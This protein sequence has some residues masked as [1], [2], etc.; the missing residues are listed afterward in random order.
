MACG[1]R[2]APAEMKGYY[3]KELAERRRLKDLLSDQLS[4]DMLRLLTQEEHA[5]ITLLIGQTRFKAHRAVLLARAPQFYRLITRQPSVEVFSV[6][7]VEP[8]EIKSFLK[9]VYSSHWHVKET[10]EHIL[11]MIE[12]VQLDSNLNQNDVQSNGFQN[13]TVSVEENPEDPKA[14]K[15]KDTGEPAKEDKSVPKTKPCMGCDAKLSPTDPAKLCPECL[16]KAAG[17]AVPPQFQDFLGWMCTSMQETF[18]SM[19]ESA[20]KRQRTLGADE[21]PSRRHLEEEDRL[22]EFESAVSSA[23]EGEITEDTGNF[24]MDKI[25]GL[26][27]SMGKTLGLSETQKDLNVMDAAFIGYKKSAS[28]FPVHSS[29]Q[30]IIKNKWKQGDKRS[31]MS[32]RF[33][34]MYPFAE[35]DI[36]TWINPLKV[37]A[38]VAQI[39]RRTTILLENGTTLRDPME[40]RTDSALKKQFST[41]GHNLK[42]AT[43]MACVFRVL[44]LWLTEFEEK[45]DSSVSR[46][47][48][49][50]EV[51]T[52]K[53]AVSYSC[54]ASLDNIRLMAKSSALSIMARRAL[55]IKAWDADASSKN[56]LVSFPFT[57]SKL[58]GDQLEEII[59]KSSGGASPFE[60]PA[61]IG[62]DLLMSRGKDQDRINALEPVRTSNASLH[63]SRIHNEAS[64]AL[65]PAPVGG[66]LEFFLDSW[67]KINPDRWV[68]QSL[69]I[70]YALEFQTV[71]L[72]AQLQTSK[73]WR[74]VML[75][76]MKTAIQ[77]LLQDRV[78]EKVPQ[79]Q[80]FRGIYSNLY[81]SKPSGDL[82]LILN[83]KKVNAFLRTRTFKMETIQTALKLIR[84]L[85]FLTRIDL[86]DAYYHIPIREVHRRFLRFHI[87]GE[88]YQYR[89]LPFGLATAP[90]VFTKILGVALAALKQQSVRVIPYLDDLLLIADSRRK[91][92]EDSSSSKKISKV[93]SQ[94]SKRVFAPDRKFHLSPTHSAMGKGSWETNSTQLLEVPEK[95]SI[96]LPDENTCS[97][98][99][100]EGVTVVEQSRSPTEGNILQGTNLGVFEG[101]FNL[102]PAS[103]F[104]KDLLSLYQNS[105]CSDVTIQIED[106]CFPAHRSI[107]CAR[108]NYFAAMLSGCWAESSRDLIHIKGI[109]QVDM[110]VIMH[111][112][113]GGILDLP[114]NADAGQILSIADMYGLEGLKD[115]A[116]YVLKRDYCKFFHKPVVGMQQ[117]VLECLCIAHTLGEEQL[118]TS[119]M[120]WIEKYFVKCWSEKNF[121]NLPAALQKNC[122]TVLVQSLSYR[123]AAFLLMESDRL[124]SNLPG[125]KWAE[126]A[127]TLASE[128]Q[129]E[130]VH[131]IVTNFSQI[132]KSESFSH[133][134][135][136]QGMSSRPYLLEQVFSEIEKNISFQNCCS[137]FM[138]LDDLFDLASTNEMGFTCKIQALRDKLWTF[139]VQSFYA[140]RHTQGWKLMRPDDQQKIQTAAFD[141]GDDRKLAKK[142]IFTSSQ[143]NRPKL[144][145]I[146]ETCHISEKK[147]HSTSELSNTRKMKSDSLGASGHKSNVTRSSSKGK[148][149]DLKGKDDKKTML[150][151]L[152]EP[153][154]TVKVV[155]A[156]PKITGK[157][158]PENNGSTKSEIVKSDSVSTSKSASSGRLGARP[159]VPNGNTCSQTKVKTLKT[160]VKEPASPVKGTV[161]S[162]KLVYSTGEPSNVNK[163]S[164]E[165]IEDGHSDESQNS[166]NYFPQSGKLLKND[167]SK[168]PGTT[169]KLKSTAKITNGSS[170]KKKVN[171]VECRGDVNSLSTKRNPASGSSDPI[172][173]KKMAAKITANCASQQRPKSAP[174]TM[175][176]KQGIGLQGDGASPPKSVSLKQT[177]IKSDT[178]LMYQSTLADKPGSLTKKTSKASTNK[179]SAK[180]TVPVPKHNSNGNKCISKNQKES[181]PKELAGSNSAKASILNHKPEQKGSPTTLKNG[182][183]QHELCQKQDLNKPDDFETPECIQSECKQAAACKL[184]DL[185]GQSSVDLT[186]TSYDCYQKQS[187]GDQDSKIQKCNLEKCCHQENTKTTSVPLHIDD[188]EHNLTEDK[189]EIKAEDADSI[190]VEVHSVFNITGDYKTEDKNICDSENS[191]KCADSSSESELCSVKEVE[192]D[193]FKQKDMQD[194]GD[195]FFSCSQDTGCT[196]HYSEKAAAPFL[197]NLSTSHLSALNCSS[198]H[199]MNCVLD[200]SIAETSE[201][202]ESSEANFTGH[203]NSHSGTLHERESPESESGSASTSSDDIKPRSEDYDAGGSQDDDGSNERGIS[204]CSTMRCHDF[205]G[206]SSSDTSTPEELKGYDCSL[207]IDV[208][209]KKES[210]SDLFR[211]NST[212]D[213]EG[214]RKRPEIWLNRDVPNHTNNQKAVCSNIQFPQETEH[215]SSS[216]D[217]TEDER[218]ETENASE[219]VMSDVAPQPFQGIVNLAFDD[220]TEIDSL[221]Q[222]VPTNKNFKRSVLL[223]VDECE[224]LGS[225]EGEPQSSQMQKTDTLTPAEVFDKISNEHSGTEY[226]GF[227]QKEDGFPELQLQNEGKQQQ[228]KIM[229]PNPVP[230]SEKYSNKASSVKEEKPA[231]TQPNKEQCDL[232]GQDIVESDL[233][234]GY[235]KHPE[236]EFKTQVRPCHLDLYTT[237]L[238][239]DS[240]RFCCAKTVNA[241]KSQLLDHQGKDSHASPTENSNDLPSGD[242]DDFDSLAQTCMYERRPSK[243]L[244][245]I[246]EVDPG[247][248]IEQSMKT[249]AKIMDFDFEDQHFVE[250]DWILLKELLA[251]HG[252]DV[253]IIN[254]VPEDLSLAQYLINQTLLL[255]RENS[256]SQGKVHVD[257]A[258]RWGDLS[259][260]YDDSTSVTGTSFSPDDCSSPH[261]E[262]TILELET[263]H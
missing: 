175:S 121:A 243:S 81:V 127:Q 205:L 211:V 83:L 199:F 19:Q 101:Q 156:K 185:S 116:I 84:P 92:T 47:R 258:S 178:R 43:A 11:G 29:I 245:P 25:D 224:E 24:S 20:R 162:G 73:I 208:K 40:E 170:I 248:G 99:H 184:V 100:Q 88:H 71:P 139:L 46:S 237:D 76:K 217:E 77:G 115:V 167:G 126:C 120:K 218:S 128:L 228:N 72:F 68:K 33:Q 63:F 189:T 130:C 203:W 82:R 255:S 148:E 153:K 145:E 96:K 159:K 247:E 12:Q 141:K 165:Q 147:N 222:H 261:G 197:Q 9:I 138:A 240:Q 210:S 4:R 57:G 181:K 39:S 105:C 58:F 195:N 54:D 26:I 191:N 41:I 223:S 30:D 155:S 133:L 183:N 209:M 246:Y 62:L 114:Q 66:R 91:A 109:N 146:K 85:S 38:A 166:A 15:P 42:S 216:A 168:D 187:I 45:I 89:A 239:S 135:Q 8:S 65:S 177:E 250:R 108:S 118:Y 169:V 254:S 150:K 253:D 206:R 49:L 48:L 154:P 53:D 37:D 160:T 35:E 110:T 229:F 142:P 70:G 198:E 1:G 161:Q 129:E 241:C 61:D 98:L 242:I 28:Q 34:R 236:S 233:C 27:K 59:K 97:S 171:E 202:P 230:P 215:L 104:G 262:W 122:L 10:E 75:S 32:R 17:E 124:L 22:I 123:N 158:K 69:E 103:E 60:K 55:W 225:D 196:M 80:H 93:K 252:S 3:A 143:Q 200:I 260:P 31:A 6:A 94:D 151:G 263:H 238:L 86:K 182:N 190:S 56:R 235:Y 87:L 194:I 174:A 172:I 212:S 14:E 113:Y 244:S 112:I 64:R 186:L 23:E 226:S 180:P 152:K 131:F 149:E 44:R 125:V 78:I 51:A 251:D 107:L 192:N 144:V 188:S 207:R 136:A 176:K 249:E 134:L 164:E 50:K 201:T 79:N 157:P 257:T 52:I 2:V 193:Y 117:S 231:E 220:V 74:K 7:N 214:P 221:G 16:K 213:D 259:S 21:G 90:R 5:D 163:S 256:K 219:K 106:R 173:Q 102:E 111:F 179:M 67:E 18:S 140:V 204:K 36:S 137:L 119:C 95:G 227:N 132:I 232:K 13:N 234:K